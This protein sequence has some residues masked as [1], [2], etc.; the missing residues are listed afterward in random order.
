MNAYAY[1]LLACI[2][3]IYICTVQYIY[4]FMYIS[5]FTVCNLLQMQ[6]GIS[7]VQNSPIERNVH[8]QHMPS[9]LLWCSAHIINPQIKLHNSVVCFT[10]IQLV[11]TY[12]PTNTRMNWNHNLQHQ[13]PNKYQQ[14][15]SQL[16]VHVLFPFNI[17]NDLIMIR[18]MLQFYYNVPRTNIP[19]NVCKF[20]TQMKDLPWKQPRNGRK[21]I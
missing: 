18:F 6:D 12:T 1:T 17:A 16:Q 20:Y 8:S 15:Q 2:Y 5:T 7:F 11:D 21:F 19:C 10:Y 3:Y 14:R 13:I 4:I 9:V